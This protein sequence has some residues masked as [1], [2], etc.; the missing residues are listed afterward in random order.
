MIRLST[1]SVLLLAA[2]GACTETT[3][4]SAQK[5]ATAPPP[6][7]PAAPRATL[8]TASYAGEYN[9]GDTTREQ[10]GGTLLVY[11]ETDSTVLLSLDV[12]NGPPSFNLGQLYRRAV[13]RGGVGRCSFKEDYDS[14]GC[15][16]RLVFAPEQVVIETEQGY[17]E[18]GFGHS[19][20]AD[21]TYRR[22]SSAVPQQFVNA[23]GTKISF[24]TT[25]PEQYNSSDQ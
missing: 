24:K 12:S 14:L 4:Q 25:S 20:S 9:W 23:E 21:E 11:P 18:C 8:Q 15:R 3:D 6:T 10:A 1:C 17:D 5:P 16:L 7:S 13:V 19:V 2:L 22:T